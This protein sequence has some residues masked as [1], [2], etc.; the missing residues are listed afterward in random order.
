[1]FVGINYAINHFT[2]QKNDLIHYSFLLR[3]TIIITR[4][5]NQFRLGLRI[6]DT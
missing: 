4:V 2:K 1:M 3:I 6:V 5:T